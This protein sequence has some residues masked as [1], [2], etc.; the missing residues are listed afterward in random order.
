MSVDVYDLEKYV[1]S[2]FGGELQAV[3]LLSKYNEN[4][5]KEQFR[6]N[7][8]LYLGRRHLSHKMLSL[9]A[10]SVSLAM[11]DKDSVSIHFQ[12]A[13]KFNVTK[14]E[15][16]DIIK[17]TKLILMSST[18]YS[19]KSSLP[20]IRANTS[21]DYKKEEI[22]KIINKV[23]KDLKSGL[24]PENFAALSHFSFDL[25]A[26]HIKEKSELLVPQK[27]DMKSIY[28]IALSVSLTIR[29]EECIHAYLKLFFEEGGTV[30]ELEDAIATTRFV[31]GNRAIV[32]FTDILKEMDSLPDE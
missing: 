30:E 19:F 28:L 8:S 20:I 26:E 5:A 2:N 25:F 24:M 12:L 1:Q 27:L 17:V 31:V 29:Y 13:K 23:K 3:N 9:L 15:M 7:T 32:Y 21:I 14:P 16:L 10:I 4:L 18:M 6:E 22:D 11:G